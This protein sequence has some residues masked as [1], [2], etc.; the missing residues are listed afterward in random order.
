MSGSSNSASLIG[1]DETPS[2]RVGDTVG[3][4]GPDAGWA[5]AYFIRAENVFL[6]RYESSGDAIVYADSAPGGARVEVGSGTDTIL[7]SAFNDSIAAGAQRDVVSGGLGNDTV[8]GQAGDDQIEDSGGDDSLDG[9]LGADTIT[10]GIGNDHLAGGD[11]R[12]TLLGGAGQDS[13][14]GGSEN[15]MLQGGAGDDDLNGGSGADSLI[16]G[17]GDDT[18][19]GASGGDIFAFEDGFGQDVILDLRRGD[20]LHLAEDLNG[21]TIRSAEDVRQFVSGGVTEAGAPYTVISIGGDTIRLERVDQ[22]DFLDNLTNYVRI[23]G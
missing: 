18:M 1:A 11:G 23:V 13:L 2:D 12:D 22:A 7:G 19:H 9:G 6:D 21:E 14:F 5:A 3:L 4:G 20:T 17:A 8:V 15:D 16:G 10:A